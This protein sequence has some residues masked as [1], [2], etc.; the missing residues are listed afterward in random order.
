MPCWPLVL[1][2]L[3]P[4]ARPP[5]APDLPPV[6]RQ[7]FDL[8]EK[9]LNLGHLE[10]SL[11]HFETCYR[12]TAK[13]AILYNLGYVNRQ[14]FERSRKMA[15]LEQAIERFKGFLQNTAG[16]TDPKALLQR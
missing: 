13:P 3:A 15:Y 6:A 16:T 7:E 14:L 2:L 9:E 4:E 12:L 8:A 10:K 1:V 11:E 5:P